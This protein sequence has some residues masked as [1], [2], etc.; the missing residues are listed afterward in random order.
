M[1]SACDSL[2]T[3]PLRWVEFTVDTTL[4][5][6]INVKDQGGLDFPIIISMLESNKHQFSSEVFSGTLLCQ[7]LGILSALTG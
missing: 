4:P 3:G 6:D 7:C 1:D 5:L 2:L